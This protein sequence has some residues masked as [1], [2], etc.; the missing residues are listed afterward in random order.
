MGVDKV[1]G[2][3]SW[4]GVGWGLIRWMVGRVGVG[5]DKVDGGKSWG[6][7]GWGLIRWMVGRVG[8][9]WG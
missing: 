4:A 5:V 6:G 8:V 2:G 9:G 7:V 1:D 3:K